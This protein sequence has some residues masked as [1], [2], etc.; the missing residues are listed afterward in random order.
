MYLNSPATQFESLSLT[1]EPN[2]EEP[3][4]EKA[5]VEVAFKS[6]SLPPSV[7]EGAIYLSQRGNSLAQQKSEELQKNPSGTPTRSPSRNSARFS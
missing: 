7:G 5:P 4:I 2:P 6:P 1:T 3:E